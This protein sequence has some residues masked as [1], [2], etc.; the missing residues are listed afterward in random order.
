MSYFL[1]KLLPPRPTFSQDITDE[2]MALMKVHGGYWQEL[3]DQGTAV[4]FGPVLDGKGGWGLAI[5]EAADEKTVRALGDNDPA[6][7]ANRGLRFEVYPMLRAVLR[8]GP[9]GR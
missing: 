6:V 2:E 7:K 5:V 4:I 8:K 1:Y 9:P 3:A